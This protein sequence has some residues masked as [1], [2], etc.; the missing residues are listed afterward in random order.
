M[1]IIFFGTAAFAVPSLEQVV[2]ARHTIVMC[3]TQPDRPQ[4]R[5]LGRE[6]SP[7]KRAATRLD[8]PLAQPERL[9]ASSVT[10]TR[11]DVGVVAA[12]GQLIPADL[13]RMPAHGMVGV[14]PSLLPKYRGAAPVAWAILN[15][16]AVTGVTIFRLSERLDAGEVMSRATV[17]IGPAEDAD[18]LT[19]RLARLGGEELVR[20]LEAV[21]AGG[22]RFEAQ[23]ES[24]ASL[25]PKLT[26]AQGRIAWEQPAEAIARLVR[27]TIPWPGATTSYQGKPLRVWSASVEDAGA[28]HPAAAPGTVIRVTEGT[29]AV[30]TG[31]GT[32][33]LGEVQPSGKR[34][35]SVNAFLAG[36]P[37]RPGD[38]F[39]VES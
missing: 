20:A 31:Q 24:A 34:R 27:A 5:G 1:R 10:A 2:A 18:A 22:V 30:A 19:N 4:G 8:L 21:D 28:T 23:D 38:A 11:P 12:Y 3:V 36:H 33:L 6:P 9:G 39:G 14:H 26:K 17:P 29:I 15:G 13:L 25:A 16:E 7:I 35:M 32:L 37:V